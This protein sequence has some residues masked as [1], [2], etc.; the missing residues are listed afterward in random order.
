M[1]RSSIILS[2][3]VQNLAKVTLLLKHSVKLRRFV[4]CGDVTACRE[5]A[6]VLSVV[7][8]A[9]LE[10]FKFVLKYT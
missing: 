6:C 2:E 1:F 7:Q 10:Q 3:L 5:M 4:S 8:T 9:V